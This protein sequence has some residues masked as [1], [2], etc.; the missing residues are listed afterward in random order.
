MEW[1]TY[2]IQNIQYNQQLIIHEHS[3]HPTITY[4]ATYNFYPFIQK[5]CD[6]TQKAE[7]S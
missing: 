1:P 3:V 4:E 7:I 5:L 2:T 6:Y